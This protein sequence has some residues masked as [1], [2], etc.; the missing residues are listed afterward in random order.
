V[1]DASNTACSANVGSLQYSDTVAAVFAGTPGATATTLA[2]SASGTYPATPVNLTLTS[3]GS[4]NYV[5]NAVNGSYA[6]TGNTPQ[7]ILFAPLP[8]LPSGTYALAAR[9]TSGLPVSYSVT[10]TGA[11]VSG[12]SL[13]LSGAS[14]ATITVTASTA[15]DPTGDYAAATP[16]AVSF[17]AQ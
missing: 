6:I 16:V 7:M 4:T 8:S 17:T 11:S 5:V 12:S 10:G 2:D 13:T 3:F 1:F 15:T 14:G 9:T